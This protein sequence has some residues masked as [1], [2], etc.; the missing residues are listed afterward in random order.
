MGS[1]SIV[2]RLALRLTPSTALDHGVG[3]CNA[4]A[5]QIRPAKR[6]LEA[7][8]RRLRGQVRALH[9]VAITGQLWIGSA[10]TFHCKADKPENK[11]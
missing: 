5:T 1:K 4:H 7:R 9:R 3:E 6:I 11:A 8:E 10:P 2:I